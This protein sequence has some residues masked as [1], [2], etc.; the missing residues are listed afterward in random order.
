MEPKFQSSFIPKGPSASTT[1][2]TLGVRGGGQKNL[3]ASLSLIIFIITVLLA[4]GVFGYKFY[5]K[6]RID[7]MGTD[8]ENAKA[9]LQPEV[10]SELTRLN[11]RIVSTEKLVS[12]H[13][14]LLP[15]FEFLEISTPKTVRF[16]DFQYLVTD[17]SLE[18]SMIG[19]ARGY[20]ALALQADI[21][22][23]SLYFK[24]HIFSDLSLSDKGDVRFVFK[25]VVD[26]DLVSYTREVEKLK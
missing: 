25:T 26:K 19:E 10:I 2:N 22:S 11:N 9:T 15:L 6:Y 17:Q 8:L 1:T 21:F 3:F 14:I 7:Q 18:L 23:K 24:N 16:I 5:I 12:N 20:A 13:Q 4:A